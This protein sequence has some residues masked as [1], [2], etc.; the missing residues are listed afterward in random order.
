[1]MTFSKLGRQGRLANQMF[2][3]AGTIGIAIK[4][5]QKYGFPK[6]INHDAKDLLGSTEDIEVL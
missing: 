2:Q 4:S 3:I 6:W 1:M 5:G